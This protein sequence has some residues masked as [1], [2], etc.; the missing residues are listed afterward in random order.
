VSEERKV[1]LATLS[2]KGH[3]LHWWTILVRD[4]SLH[5]EPTIEYGNDKK[6]ALRRRHIPS[7]YHRELM[8]KIHRCNQIN[9]NIEEYR[10]KTELYMMRDGIREDESVT[11]ARF[12]S[13]LSLEIRDRVELLPFRDF[14][15]LV[16]ICI[17]VE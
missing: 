17:K 5:H 4:K 3:A 15:D 16:H 14:H 10:Q 2:F 6:S 7:Y 11:M 1:P 13:G 12:M 8:E 9:M